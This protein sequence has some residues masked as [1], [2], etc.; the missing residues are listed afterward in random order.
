M[1]RVMFGTVLAAALAGG[2]CAQQPAVDNSAAHDSAASIG[3]DRPL[4]QKKQKAA[5]SRTLNGQVVDDTGK[6][7]EGALVT[8]TNM[9]TKER[10]EFFTKKDGRYNFADLNFNIDYQVQ[11]R[12]KNL[13][14]ELRKLSQYDKAPK[15]VRILQINPDAAAPAAVEA[16]KADAP[17]KQ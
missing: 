9:A 8:L 10:T 14:S 1:K 2:L 11:A 4:I 12:Y 3:N 6:P 13:N 7:L 16:K 15:M 5:T 17:A